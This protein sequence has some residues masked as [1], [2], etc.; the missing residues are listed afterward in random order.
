[1]EV[2]PSFRKRLQ[3]PLGS[4]WLPEKGWETLSHYRSVFGSL[5]IMTFFRSFF[6][7]FQLRKVDWFPFGFFRQHGQIPEDIR[8]GRGRE[9]IVVFLTWLSWKRY[10]TNPKR[11]QKNINRTQ[12]T[13]CKE[14]EK[15]QIWSPHTCVLELPPPSSVYTAVAV[16]CVHQG[17][18]VIDCWDGRMVRERS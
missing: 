15:N 1:M 5:Q 18:N 6:F 3:S 7:S 12:E 4:A 17:N 14:M 16:A 8:R 11:Q 2:S 13:K 10:W 9:F